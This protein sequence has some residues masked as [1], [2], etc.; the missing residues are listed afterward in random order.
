MTNHWRYTMPILFVD[1]YPEVKGDEYGVDIQS[2]DVD[3]AESVDEAITFL[4]SVDYDKMYLDYK[5]VGGTGTDILNWLADHP[6]RIP[7]EIVS[8]SFA[9]LDPHFLQKIQIIVSKGREN[10]SSNESKVK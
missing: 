4:K 3:I 10:I 7:K 6:D 9:P 5:L 8:I 2:P 1:D